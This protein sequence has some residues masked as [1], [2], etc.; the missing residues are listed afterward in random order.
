MKSTTLSVAMHTLVI[1]GTVSD[2]ASA[3][4]AQPLPSPSAANLSTSF[5]SPHGVD[6][7][8][9]TEQKASMCA[10]GE[11]AKGVADVSHCALSQLNCV[12]PWCSAP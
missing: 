12:S 6:A 8:T 3:M 2:G 7:S 4:G 9:S 5:T 1:S 11:D 10:S